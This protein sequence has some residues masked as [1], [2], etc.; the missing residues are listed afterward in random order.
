MIFAL[1][2]IP[3]VLDGQE[4][5]AADLN[6]LSQNT[7][8][9][10]QIVNGPDRLFLSS[11][12]Y[13]P[14]TFLLTV[15]PNARQT[16]IGF[17]LTEIDVWEGS[18][19]YREGMHTVR[20]AFQSYPA[21]EEWGKIKYYPGTST[22]F[23][24]GVCLF[25]SFKYIDVSIEQQIKEQ[26]KY[27]KYN[28][29]W[30]YY[31]GYQPANNTIPIV[32]GLVRS[33]EGITYAE[34]D[35]T[36]MDLT[37]GEVVPLKFRIAGYDQQYRDYGKLLMHW[38]STYYFSMIYANIAHQIVPYTWTNINS[39]DS[40]SQIKELVSNQQYLI[41]YFRLADY[42]LRASIWDQVLGGS[43][44]FTFKKVD[45][46][47]ADSVRNSNYGLL[48]DRAYYFLSRC[49]Q[50]ARY[51]MQKK[52]SIKD[53]ISVSYSASTNTNTRFTMLGVLSKAV[54]NA[55]HYRYDRDAV[56]TGTA[57]DSAISPIW[58]VNY[59]PNVL[60]PKDTTSARDSTRWS[61]DDAGGP[62]PKFARTGILQT[63][64]SGSRFPASGVTAPVG[65]K[66]PGYYLFYK[67]TSSNKGNVQPEFNGFYFINPSSFN[68]VAYYDAAA[69]SVIG[70]STDYFA[71]GAEK[72]A[73]FF[74][75]T[76][77]FKFQ[78]QAT[79][80]NST[81]FYPLIYEAYSGLRNHGEYFIQDSDSYTDFS[82]DLVENSTAGTRFFGK[83]NY[84]ATF[85]LTDVSVRNGSY[86]MTPFTRLNSF[87]SVCYS[88]LLTQLNGINT[89]LNAVK[90][91]VDALDAYRYIPLFWTK[92]KSFLAHHDN[93]SDSTTPSNQRFYAKLENNAVYFSNTRQADY[94]IV[95]G[96]NVQIGWGGFDKIYR[97]NPEGV[98]PAALQFEYVN[99]Q[100]LTGDTI[101]TVVIGL[102]SLEGL[103]HGERYYLQG[104]I[105][106]AA[107]TMGVP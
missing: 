35:I 88:G 24:F 5:A 46:F 100:S 40:L 36:G 77:N 91:A 38:Q 11:W 54:T 26:A 103:A 89:R 37:P 70:V 12:A 78:S 65:Y 51:Y 60:P 102:D 75:D 41:N 86:I 50:Q 1:A 28:F 92:P 21:W 52:F 93:Q 67:N 106:Y 83:A 10:E 61:T 104:K 62:Q 105:I 14:P 72:N 53:T 25:A 80:G 22:S 56:E 31:E 18:F 17:K 4:L 55:G 47:N 90:N 71:R 66:D 2:N 7:E 27:A 34:F 57:K 44:F 69:T 98:W 29:M 20:V 95:R 45:T 74:S 94:L 13:A 101:E 39:V 32:S 8:I 63:M 23:N 76:F 16:D 33:H 19:V 81:K 87:D 48:T 49:S 73:L 42:P 3:S 59:K 68:P 107:E 82:V 97:D 15:D 84:I 30:K 96:Q 99:S 64:V 9:L 43:S 85:R 6:N 58:I 79:V